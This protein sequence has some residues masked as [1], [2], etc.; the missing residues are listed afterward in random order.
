MAGSSPRKR[1]TDLLASV[2]IELGTRLRGLALIPLLI[3]EVG[4]AGYGAYAQ[5]ISLSIMTA[6]VATAGS[7]YSLVR[8]G[9]DDSSRSKYYYTAILITIFLGGTIGGIFAITASTVSKVLLQTHVYDSVFLVGGGLIL[10]RGIA[11]V[12]RNYY[13]SMNRI[14]TFNVVRGGMAYLSLAGVSLVIFFSKASVVEV[15]LITAVSEI[16]GLLMVQ[17]FISRVAELTTPNIKSIRCST[18]Y[19]VEVLISNIASISLTRA[20]RLLVGAFLGAASVGIYDS[21]YRLISGIRIIMRPLR[22]LSFPEFADLHDN[23]ELE[24]IEAFVAQG[25]HLLSVS[26]LPIVAGGYLVGDE[27]FSI[28]ITDSPGVNNSLVGI[29]AAGIFLLAI[30]DFVGQVYYATDRTRTMIHSTW[31]VAILNLGLNLIFIP[32]FGIFAAGITTF[33]SYGLLMTWLI[34]KL[35]RYISLTLPLREVGL[36]LLSC[37][38]MIVCVMYTPWQSLLFRIGTGTI[39]YCA[40]IFLSGAFRTAHLFEPEIY[41]H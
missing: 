8:H 23:G 16:F 14:K 17:I 2:S 12:Q 30:G 39:V 3:G 40:L 33:V 18:G 38:V 19:G 27:L 29:I 25:I 15:V 41:I 7:E 6:Q 9:S 13:R 21:L 34:I 24:K 26:M 35:R 22:D 36:T 4:V 5:V 32:K 28:I 31:A 11:R 20:D 1:I 37:I 10:I